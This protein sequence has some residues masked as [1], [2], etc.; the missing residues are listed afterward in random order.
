MSN[1]G[2]REMIQYLISHGRDCATPEV[3]EIKGQTYCTKDLTRYEEPEYKARPLTACT[4]TA[5]IDYLYGKKEE[6]RPS[7]IIHVMSP[8]K[9]T[10]ISGL[11]DKRERETLFVAETNP[12]GFVFDKYYDQESFVINMQT[13]FVQGDET[14][15]IL[16]VAGNVENKTVANYGDDGMSQKATISKGI[17]GKTDVIVPNPVTLKPF[18]T[19]LEVD[20]PESKFVFRIGEY[21]NGEPS[22]KLVEA[23]GGVWKYKAVSDICDF[24]KSNI[25]DDLKNMITVI[26]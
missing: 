7:M 1:S 19:F 16:S 21:S 23:D 20:Q 13:S 9:V 15:M 10:L 4:L 17:A 22:F 12:N 3:L 6:L 25:P 26:G 5:L 8:T 14:S 11:T 18:R 24:L 2:L